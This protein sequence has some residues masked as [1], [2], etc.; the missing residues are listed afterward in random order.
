MVVKYISSRMQQPQLFHMIYQ[1]SLNSSSFI[2]KD[3][4]NIAYNK[5]P[6]ECLHQNHFILQALSFN[7]I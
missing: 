5:I 3:S 1:P 6:G 2:D 4:Y 7:I